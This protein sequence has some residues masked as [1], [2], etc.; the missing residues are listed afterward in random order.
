MTI[1]NNKSKQQTLTSNN[2]TLQIKPKIVKLNSMNQNIYFKRCLTVE[3]LNYK[4][5]LLKYNLNVIKITN[6]YKNL[7]QV[8][9]E[10]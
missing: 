7:R 8:T 9:N 1:Y 5:F 2:L 10:T 3:K 6:C 4:S